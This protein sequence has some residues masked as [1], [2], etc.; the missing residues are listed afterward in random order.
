MPG[1]IVSVQVGQCGNEI[2]NEFWKR[3]CMEH[4]IGHDGYATSERCVPDQATTYFSMADGDRFV[5]RAVLIDLE[6]RVLN[7]TKNSEF[8]QIFNIE[9][10]FHSPDGGGAGNN[11]ATGY[12][13]GWSGQSEVA[14]EILNLIQSEVEICDA[15]DGFSLS[16][17]IAGG[18]G[19]G[20]GSWVLEK[21]YDDFGQKSIITFS[22]F[23]SSGSD[24]VVQ[25]YNAT[26]TLERLIE[27]PEMVVILDNDA[28]TR[29]AM[30]KMH[31]KNPT[32]GDVNAIIGR[33]MGGITAP[34]R[35]GSYSYG[36]LGSLA[37]HLGPVSPLHFVQCGLAPLT[38]P[39]SRVPQRTYPADLMQLLSRPDS[40]MTTP[41]N[42]FTAGQTDCLIAGAAIFQGPVKTSDVLEAMYT[43]NT[44]ASFGAS[45]QPFNDIDPITTYPHAPS[46]SALLALNHSNF[47]KSLRRITEQYDKMFKNKAYINNFTKEEYFAEGLDR[48][49]EAREK[50]E[51]L[52]RAYA[53]PW[54]FCSPVD[55]DAE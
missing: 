30:T 9:R 49:A 36:S 6:P 19:S 37:A 53:D 17:S 8:G 27:F 33:I 32:M 11:W 23:P 15:L 34:I 54:R 39:N 3:L 5:P 28:I 7:A 1:D 25:P 2:G 51:Q 43:A 14:E 42:K 29:T 52:A 44:K 21:L 45:L 12:G 10:V 47:E 35:F 16:H 13:A 24:V 4:A 38:M 18:T 22:V 46:R 31:I 41:F 50:V 20:L 55:G 48:M 26:L 40:I